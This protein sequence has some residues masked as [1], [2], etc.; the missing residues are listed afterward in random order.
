MLHNRTTLDPHF[1][2][3]PELSTDQVKNLRNLKYFYKYAQ[4]FLQEQSK[5]QADGTIRRNASIGSSIS[6]NHGIS[7]ANLS[8]QKMDSITHMAGSR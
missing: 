5:N 3:Q 6:F 2:F 7:G 4:S 8:Y 1:A